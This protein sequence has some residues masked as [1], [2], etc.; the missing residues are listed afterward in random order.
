MSTAIRGEGGG[1]AAGAAAV[2]GSVAGDA[3]TA[4]Q[5]AGAAS[6]PEPHAVLVSGVGPGTGRALALA[7]ARQRATLVLSCRNPEAIAEIVEACREAGAPAVHA[8]SCDITKPEQRAALVARVRELTGR[9]DVLVNNAFATGRI[10]PIA[11][12]DPA[13][14]W[15]AAFEVNVFGTVGL[16]ADC[17][18]LMPSGSSI[19]S[20]STLAA[21]KAHPG[22]AGY[23]ASKAALEAAMRAL[24][25]EAAP[26]GVRVNTI[27]PSHIDGPNLQAGI[28][29]EAQ[30]RGVSD[31]QVRAGYMDQGLLRHITTPEEIADCAVFL[32]SPAAR[33]ITG[34]V[35]H[36]NNGQWLP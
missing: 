19:V 21:H 18:S 12:S 25:V 13:R 20:I 36:L 11:G 31:E 16:C 28:R 4:D 17:L 26:G 5:L 3:G 32:A 24:A 9:L 14:A 10:A 8:V 23:G 33:S 34:Q 29:I 15:R 2:G 30:I 22:L 7:F 6:R 35:L 27:T 1:P